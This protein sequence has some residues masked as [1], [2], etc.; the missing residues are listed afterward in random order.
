MQIKIFLNQRRG[1]EINRSTVKKIGQRLQKKPDSVTWLPYSNKLFLLWWREH[2]NCKLLC[3]LK[4]CTFRL[5]KIKKTRDSKLY[6]TRKHKASQKSVDVWFLSIFYKAIQLESVKA[7][8]IEDYA[9]NRTCMYKCSHC[10][11]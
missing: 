4:Y 1:A 11:M 7:W 9:R 2:Y 5:C 6:I 10:K 3:T 8:Q